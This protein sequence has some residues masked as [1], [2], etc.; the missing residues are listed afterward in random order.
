MRQ[1]AR[2][3]S[4]LLLVSLLAA[5][6]ML[7]K[8]KGAEGKGKDHGKGHP[9]AHRGGPPPHAAAKSLEVPPGHLPPAGSC[10]IWTPGVPPGH[11][12][13]AGP[14]ARLERRLKPGDWLL[15]RSKRDP[16]LV[17]VD[18]P[19]VTTTAT[20][21]REPGPLEVRVFQA[22]TGIF[23]RFADPRRAYRIH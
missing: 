15:Y 21:V 4:L 14:C 1:L 19:R 9:P 13:P 20:R 5:A 12:A 7:A 10:R 22:S 8:D 2:F 18:V 16:D 11:Q 6:P 23:V 17:Y 3:S